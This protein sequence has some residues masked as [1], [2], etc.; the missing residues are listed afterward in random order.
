VYTCARRLD[1]GLCGDT[2]DRILE[3]ISVA[4]CNK[5]ELA[6]LAMGPMTMKI[7]AMTIGR[8][9]TVQELS[10]KLG[11]SMVSCYNIVNKLT[12][13]GFLA[14]TEK[15][16]TS[17]HGRAN[18]YTAIA[19]SGYINVRDGCIEI[20]FNYKDGHVCFQ[21]DLLLEDRIE[22]EEESTY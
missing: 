5:E 3:A 19:K 14:C 16:R 1:E 18:G 4:K 9:L 21:K 10:E 22:D 15:I 12:E 8:K 17:T 20:C 7:V 13:L 2:E 6:E 11:I